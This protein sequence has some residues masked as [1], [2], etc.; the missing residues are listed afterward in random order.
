MHCS[1]T[2]KLGAKKR[3][4]SRSDRNRED[5]PELSRLA[6]RLRP[7]RSPR[8]CNSCASVVF[9]NNPAL[10]LPWQNFCCPRS[11]ARYWTKRR[12][13][14]NGENQV[15]R[16]LAGEVVHGHGILEQGVVSRHDC[17][18][19]FSHKVPLP[20]SLAV[21]SDRRTFRNV[22]VAIDDGFSDAAMP[23]HINV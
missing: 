4:R 18:S 14:P 1:R 17:N 12:D 8:R 19:T 3:R 11:A 2:A 20:I 16:L 7:M 23:S 15:Y 10:A 21:I 9:R 13:G 6:D 22:H 5:R